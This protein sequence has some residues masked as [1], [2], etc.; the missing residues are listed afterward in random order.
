MVDALHSWLNKRAFEYEK[1]ADGSTR[2][3]M[4][5]EA[6]DLLTKL[7]RGNKKAL[8]TIKQNV[9]VDEKYQLGN[10]DLITWFLVSV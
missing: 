6:K 2:K 1:Q 3:V 10:F 4:G 5:S 9:K 8:E 7:R